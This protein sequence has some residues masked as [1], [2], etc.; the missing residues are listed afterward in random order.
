MTQRERTLAL[1]ETA[2]GFGVL[3]TTFVENG[4]RRYSA[5]INELRAEGYEIVSVCV[6][7]KSGEWKSTL[8]SAPKTIDTPT[9]PEDFSGAL[10]DATPEPVNAIYG[11][12]A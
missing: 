5:R 3:H 11:D 7:R 4:I 12:A 6:D 1:L 9:E 10:F 2:G 8:K